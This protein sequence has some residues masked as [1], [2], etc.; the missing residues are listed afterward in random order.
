MKIGPILVVAVVTSVLLIVGVTSCSKNSNPPPVHDTVVQKMDTPDL[1]NGLLVYLKFN[2]N[3]ADSSGNNNPTQAVNGAVLTSD[4][5]GAANSAFG[6]TGNGQRVLV[7]NNGAIK[8]DTAFSLAYHVMTTSTNLQDIVTMVQNAN[9]Q[10]ATFGQGLFANTT[11]IEL[12]VMDSSATCSDVINPGVNSKI[13]STG[14]SIQP[15]VWYNVVSVYHKGTIQIYVDGNLVSQ[16]SGAERTVP[17]CPSAKLVIGGWWDGSNSV[18]LNGKLDEFRLYNRVLSAKEISW[19]AR[20]YQ[21]VTSK[22]SPS[23]HEGK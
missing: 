3:F 16:L 12:T 7:T 15:Y 2:G 19:L 23:L 17:I 1:N 4:E 22:F 14:F 9:G 8:F 11:D 6:G 21:P 18:S 5:R 13:D 10:G 20:N